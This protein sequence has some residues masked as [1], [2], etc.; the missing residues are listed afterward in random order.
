MNLNFVDNNQKTS[1]GL[2][3]YQNKIIEMIQQKFPNTF[4]QEIN[5]CM[6]MDFFVDYW[7]GNF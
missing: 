6:Y 2:V 7:C 1:D 4:H 3:A 5:V